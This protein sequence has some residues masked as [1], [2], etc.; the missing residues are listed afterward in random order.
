MSHLSEEVRKRLASA[1]RP[2]VLGYLCWY[3][4]LNRSWL[5]FQNGCRAIGRGV[6]LLLTEGRVSNLVPWAF[7]HR[8][9]GSLAESTVGKQVK[10]CEAHECEVFC[11]MVLSNSL[12]QS[13]VS[14]PEQIICIEE[15]KV[16]IK[17][18]FNSSHS[19]D[20]T[21][22]AGFSADPRPFIKRKVV[23]SKL[24]FI[25]KYLDQVSKSSLG[26]QHNRKALQW[27]TCARD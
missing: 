6:W 9:V 27:G 13:C 15:A 20:A 12:H 14:S 16:K 22:L 1:V 11:M 17:T 19:D 26:D 18:R 21:E 24:K 10:E 25:L 2:A 7:Q 4:L 8:N 5:L 3:L 23:D